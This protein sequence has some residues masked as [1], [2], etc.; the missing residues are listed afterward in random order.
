VRENG[1]PLMGTASLNLFNY[2]TWSDRKLDDLIAH[3]V[4]HVLGIGSWGQGPYTGLVDGDYAASDPIFTGANALAVFN[5]LGNSHRFARRPI[6]L[7]LGVLGHWR[8]DAFAGELMSPIFNTLPQQ[9]SAVTVAALQDLGWTVE[10]E[11]YDDYV[12]PEGVLTPL[13][14]QK[15]GV[16]LPSFV[17]LH[18]EVLKPKLLIVTGRRN[19]A[20]DST[21]RPI[22]K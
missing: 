21:G 12:L 2:A 15:A 5:R 4:G 7:E 22:L 10:R 3:E 9:T 17:S 18:D 14:S 20:L 19:V 16:A 1:L 13:P 6:P 8:G 11:A